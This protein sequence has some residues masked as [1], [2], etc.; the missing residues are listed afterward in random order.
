MDIL[1]NVLTE[2]ANN[3]ILNLTLAIFGI[4][5]SFYMDRRNRRK[6][7][8]LFK[9]PLPCNREE[10]K[11]SGYSSRS[12]GNVA[13]LVSLRLPIWNG[14]LKTIDN[15]DIAAKDPLRICTSKESPFI[16]ALISEKTNIA[17]DFNCTI[18]QDQKFVNFSFEYLESRDGAI[19]DLIYEGD[20]HEDILIYGSVKG[21]K[22]PTEDM[23]PWKQ[24]LIMF[25]IISIVGTLTVI[26]GKQI[27]NHHYYFGIF[28]II[29]GGLLYPLYVIC[30]NT[31]GR[32]NRIPPKFI[33]YMTPPN[34]LE[35]VMKNHSQNNV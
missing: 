9:V 14:G 26:T 33:K 13:K 19:I 7:K 29:F 6:T 2:I 23:L 35:F 11:V 3:P 30:Y 20:W 24:I 15:S 4:L 12:P 8:I 16:S 31:I 22:A 25:I 18:S 32:K 1:K 34:I 28:L 5:S 17:N 10:Q 27:M 21:C